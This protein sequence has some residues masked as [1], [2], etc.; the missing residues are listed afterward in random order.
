VAKC[1][2]KKMRKREIKTGESPFVLYFLVNQPF[3]PRHMR[4]DNGWAVFRMPSKILTRR[5]LLLR[6]VEKTGGGVIA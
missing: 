3:L 2:E 5:R 6:M 4:G 1:G